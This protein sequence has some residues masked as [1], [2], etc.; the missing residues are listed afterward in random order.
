MC[1]FSKL[2]PHK[3]EGFCVQFIGGYSQQNNAMLVEEFNCFVVVLF[4]VLV[5]LTFLEV[6]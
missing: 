6:F 3:V 1:Y 2:K 5:C 4:F